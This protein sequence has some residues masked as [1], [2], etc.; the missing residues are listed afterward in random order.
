MAEYIN[1]VV[2]NELAEQ[3]VSNCARRHKMEV[4]AGRWEVWR[5]RL[6][7]LAR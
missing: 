2:D 6:G 5:G 7:N 4:V 1:R 3:S